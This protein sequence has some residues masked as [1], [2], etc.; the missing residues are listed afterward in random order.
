MALLK[1][2]DSIKLGELTKSL[3]FKLTDT[4]PAKQQK[5]QECREKGSSPKLTPKPPEAQTEK[6]EPSVKVEPLVKSEAPVKSAEPVK[7]VEP[8]KLQ[9][10][11]SK[12][13]TPK[14]D[15]FTTKPFTCSWRL[16]GHFLLA[17]W[18]C[19]QTWMVDRILGKRDVGR[20]RKI[21]THLKRTLGSTKVGMQLRSI[22][23]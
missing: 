1:I 11:E 8:G 6:A 9:K 10:A 7:S 22:T 13:P 5:N 14:K 4:V 21:H 19:R 12:T 23:Y 20:L 3:K 17:G 16:Q 2:G 18:K 15:K